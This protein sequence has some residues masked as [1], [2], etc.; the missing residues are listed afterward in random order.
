MKQNNLLSLFLLLILAACSTDETI[1]FADDISTADGLPRVPVAFTVSGEQPEFFGGTPAAADTRAFSWDDI[2]SLDVLVFNGAN[3]VVRKYFDR[4]A[5]SAGMTLEVP[6]GTGLVAYAFANVASNVFD[7]IQTLTDLNNATCTIAAWDDIAKWSTVPMSGQSNSFNVV[8]GGAAPSISFTLRRIVAQLNITLTGPSNVTI[9]SMKL[10]NLPKK[11]YYLSRPLDTERQLA[12]DN[13]ART[14]KDAV[15][16][17]N[18]GD[19][20]TASGTQSAKTY[21]FYL[22]ENRPGVSTNTSEAKKGAKSGDTRATYLFITGEDNSYTMEWSLYV[23]ADATKNYNIKRN[24]VYTINATLKYA[25]ATTDVRVKSVAKW[26][27]LPDDKAARGSFAGSNIYWDGSKLTFDGAGTT[28]KQYYQGVYF[29][30]GSL[31][32]ISP[33]AQGSGS[34]NRDWS[35]AETIYRTT[36]YNGPATG[37]GTKP[38]W[39]TPVAASTVYSAYANIPYESDAFTTYD[40]SQDHLNYSSSTKTTKWSAYKGDI[41]RYLGEIGAAP[42]GYRMPRDEEFVSGGFTVGGTFKIDYALGTADGKKDF[43]AKG[44]AKNSAGLYFP[45]AGLR[46]TNGQLGYPGGGGYYW[47]SSAG[48]AANGFNLYFNNEGTGPSG[49][50]GRQ[51]ALTVRCVKD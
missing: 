13:T 48:N 42:S 47:S 43:S 28:S 24:C 17:G 1:G 14:D 50:Y 29:R 37:G 20:I 6:E 19:W 2:N 9:S 22:F 34:N 16:A 51:I 4:T 39:N 30:W 12:D 38:T 35:G 44:W 40:K 21:T 36:A 33:A 23:G 49:G 32:G 27:P 3:R 11:T 8:V 18:T 41:C 10:V 7:N 26:G 25:A 5:L 15:V 31:V 45:T 46:S